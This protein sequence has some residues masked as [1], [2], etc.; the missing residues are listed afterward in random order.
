[1]NSAFYKYYVDFCD[2]EELYKLGF[3]EVLA[4][5]ENFLLYDRSHNVR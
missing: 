4:E 1:M 2:L 3:G 5:L